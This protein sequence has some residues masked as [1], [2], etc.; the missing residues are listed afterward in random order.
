MRGSVSLAAALALPLAIDSGGA[1]PERDLIV[2]L[3]F[4][5]IL[6]TLV[7]QGL[8]LPWL[9]HRLGVRD[10]D[11]EQREELRARMMAAHAARGA[12]DGLADEE[13]T[14]DDTVERMRGL[15]DYRMRRFKAQAGKIDGT[16]GIEER[17]VNYQRMLH[18]VIEAQRQALVQMR[19]DGTISTDVM[20]RVEHELDLEEG[21]LEI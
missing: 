18:I 4:A 2:F 12:V 13:W 9:I 21:R 5:V 14:R 19:N 16:D 17:S 7:L 10:D 1:F 6:A 20:R 8:S 15:Y 11:G 3:T